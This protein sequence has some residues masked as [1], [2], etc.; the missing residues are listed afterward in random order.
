[1]VCSILASIALA[2]VPTGLPHERHGHRMHALGSE[3]IVFGGFSGESDVA[4]RGMKETWIANLAT[5][6]WRRGP[7]MKAPRAFFASAEVEGDLY[8][9]GGTVEKLAKG[10]VA[11]TKFVVSGKLPE[12]HFSA[13]TLGNRIYTIGGYPADSGKFQSFDTRTGMVRDEPPMPGYKPGDHFHIVASLNNRIH[14]IGGY[15][16]DKFVA[17]STH[18]V[19]DGK[20]WSVAA[21]PKRSIWAKFSVIQTV[22][23]RVYVFDDEHGA[24]YDASEDSWQAAAPMPFELVMPA[25]FRWGEKFVVVGGGRDH[26]WRGM[27]EYVLGSNSW[28][29]RSNR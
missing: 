13:A 14:V 25:S 28:T 6:R 22:G 10:S 1:M 27:L 2:Q 9:I 5:W 12:T 15:D 4:D 8:A 11:W 24:V 3:L 20:T 23:D 7:N 26:G 19:F 17:L 16:G 29:T 21:K 18:N